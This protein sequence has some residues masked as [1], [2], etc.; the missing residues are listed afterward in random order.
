MTR[1]SI[2]FTAGVWTGAGLPED[3]ADHSVK[4][5]ARDNAT[6]QYFLVDIT[7]DEVNTGDEAAWA[8]DSVE[9][10]IDP[11]DDGDPTRLEF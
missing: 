11:E 7:D 1:T 3:N 9:F 4:I 8:N 5:Y 2:C 10:Y 6:H